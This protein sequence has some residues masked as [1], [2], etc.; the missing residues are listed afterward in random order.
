[1]ATVNLQAIDERELMPGF[2]G[3]FV[4]TNSMTLAD[5]Q[6]DAGAELPVH[7]HP[8]EQVVNVLEGRF[9]LV[10]DGVPHE[11]EPG[12]VLP[13]PGGVPHSGR[14]LTACRILDVFSPVREDYR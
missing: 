10:L 8:H 9:E 3:R 2:R 7:D 6:I 4:H 12:T 14:A 13:I 1:M 11:L 5:W